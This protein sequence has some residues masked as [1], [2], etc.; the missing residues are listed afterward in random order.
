MAK[1]NY[2]PIILMFLLSA[3]GI[4]ETNITNPSGLWYRNEGGTE[5]KFSTIANAYQ[6]TQDCTNLTAQAPY[7]KSVKSLSSGNI[8][9]YDKDYSIVKTTSDQAFI[10]Q[11]EFIHHLFYINTGDPD[12]CHNSNLFTTC[13]TVQGKRC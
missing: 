11:H 1:I 10:L 9:S 3:C 13:S 4:K 2:T 8:A 7:V 6:Y 5:I 12:S